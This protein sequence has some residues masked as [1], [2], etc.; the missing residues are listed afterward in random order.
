M[1]FFLNSSEFDFFLAYLTPSLPPTP[2]NMV[3][4]KILWVWV[5]P[6][7]A[8]LKLGLFQM[9]YQGIS[10]SVCAF[11]FGASTVILSVHACIPF[12]RG[13]GKW[14]V[15]CSC[16]LTPVIITRKD[17]AVLCSVGHGRA[18]RDVKWVNR[19]QC[20]RIAAL[21]PLKVTF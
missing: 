15:P 1:F 11:A 3:L 17:G 16:C 7:S 12:C 21:C 8:F 13:K 19:P 10:K 14:S 4:S 5:L 6:P 20:C 18:P 9:K 2:S